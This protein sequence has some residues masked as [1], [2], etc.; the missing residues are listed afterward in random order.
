[1]RNAI[2]RARANTFDDQRRWEEKKKTHNGKGEELYDESRGAATNA[3]GKTQFSAVDRV[4]LCLRFVVFI[5]PRR[6]RRVSHHSDYLLIYF[7]LCD[8]AEFS[9]QMQTCIPRQPATPTRPS[10][11]KFM[12]WLDHWHFVGDGNRVQLG[13]CASLALR[14]LQI[15]VRFLCVALISVAVHLPNVI[16]TWKWERDRER[17]RESVRGKGSDSE[18]ESM[19]VFFT[20]P[21]TCSETFNRMRA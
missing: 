14:M 13:M 10:V 12:H 15:C 7:N 11:R 9:A 20:G 4:A 2:P 19:R 16:A 18:T 1:M 17:K 8:V 6:L 5:S 3:R 21:M